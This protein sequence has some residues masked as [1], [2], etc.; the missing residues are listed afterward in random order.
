MKHGGRR[1]NPGT[2]ISP[3]PRSG[4]PI[5]GGIPEQQTLKTW[6]QANELPS[7]MGSQSGTPAPGIPPKWGP[8]MGPKSH[9]YFDGSDGRQCDFAHSTLPGEAPKWGPQNPVL[10][11]IL[12]VPGASANEGIP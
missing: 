8:K 3:Y 11:P 10:D 5:L 4:D 1:M 2:W 6:G 12:R 9:S 7:K